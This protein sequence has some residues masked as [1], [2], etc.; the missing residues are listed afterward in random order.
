MRGMK[1]LFAI[2]LTVVIGAIGFQ[3]YG[4][5][6]QGRALA[7]E[8]RALNA[9]VAKIEEDNHRIKEDLRY[10]SD[11]RNLE[12]EL[13]SIF[14]YRKPGEELLIVIPKAKVGTSTNETIKK[15]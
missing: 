11:I 12:K 10:L 7:E 1:I 8:E 4:L 14:N 9:E 15:N 13:K 2:I 3:I 6:S 5:Y